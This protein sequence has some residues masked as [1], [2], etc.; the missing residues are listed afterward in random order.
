MLE[1]EP[2]RG[3]GRQ[4]GNNGEVF[5]EHL[6]DWP[7]QEEASNGTKEKRLKGS[8][9]SWSVCHLSPGMCTSAEGLFCEHQY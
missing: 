3:E 6:L 4:G 9:G 2:I 8:G 1:L 5:S 7:G